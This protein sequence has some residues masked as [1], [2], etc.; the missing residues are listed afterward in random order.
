MIEFTVKNDK[1]QT[2]KWQ[3]EMT[4]LTRLATKGWTPTTLE[5][6]DK[7]TISINDRE[8]IE[9]KTDLTQGEKAGILLNLYGGKG[10]VDEIEVKA[11]K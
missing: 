4:S 3:G 8:V 9:F 10:S 11:I 6:G 5:P 7:I 2:E 1:G